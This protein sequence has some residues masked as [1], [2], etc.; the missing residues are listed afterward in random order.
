MIL[1]YINYILL[2]T[3]LQLLL[4]N[5]VVNIYFRI[6][7]GYGDILPVNCD[8]MILCIITMLIACALFGYSLN[9]IGSIISE[10]FK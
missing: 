1:V 2:V 7:V 10:H 5:Y 3:T 9:T 4:C 8:E 6:T